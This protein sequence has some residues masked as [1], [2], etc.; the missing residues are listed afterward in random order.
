MGKL[1]NKLADIFTYPA[2]Y[3]RN[4]SDRKAT[5]FA[6]IILIGAIDLL[7]PDIAAVFEALFS[8]KSAGDIRFNALMMVFVILLLGIIDVVF[9][10]VPLFDV[11][12][13][14]KKKEIAM[15]QH[16]GNN[17]Y[18]S[19]PSSFPSGP[20]NWESWDQ[21]PSLIKVMKVYI[22]SHFIVIPATTF[23]YFALVR[24]ITESSPAWMQNLYLLI[25][26]LT[27]I[28]SAA[29][30][31]RGINVIFS[32]NP[33]FKRL[34]YIIVLIWNFIFSMVFNMQIMKWMLMLFRR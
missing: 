8:G 15:G 31:T 20:D 13:F 25:F 17:P 2:K 16:S 30:I 4:L 5:L 27:F 28:W 9:V 14:L 10:S 19:L 29:I 32:F 7:L 6:G 22:I 33:L 1:K 26:V 18:H 11:F 23:V 3:Y 12:R 21:R 24:N 34:T